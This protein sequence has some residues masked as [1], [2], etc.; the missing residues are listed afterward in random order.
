MLPTEPYKKNGQSIK[1]IANVRL[2]EV[3][4]A[5]EDYF[6][7]YT[8][9]NKDK[10]K[11]CE[12][13][14][15]FKSSKDGEPPKQAGIKFVYQQK[16]LEFDIDFVTYKTAEKKKSKRSKKSEDE[17]LPEI[18][19]RFTLKKGLLFKLYKYIMVLNTLLN[20]YQFTYY[21]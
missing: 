6:K 15:I 10:P 8:S 1:L 11:G 4:D 21:K 17:S 19:L 9:S 13:K 16:G 14:K 18:S 7:T 3:L 2:D 12:V 20:D 5:I